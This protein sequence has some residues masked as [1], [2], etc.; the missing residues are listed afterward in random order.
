MKYQLL[1]HPNTIRSKFMKRFVMS[2]EEFCALYPDTRISET[3]YH[4]LYMWDRMI[5]RYEQITFEMALKM[6]RNK[7]DNVIFISESQDV[8]A[9]YHCEMQN[10]WEDINGAAATADM[11][12]L[13][14]RISYEWYTSYEMWEQG[15]QFED[16]LL[17]D[18]L[19]VFDDTYSWC[20]IFTHETVDYSEKAEARLCFCIN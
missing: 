15:C 12:E 4:S 2:Y 17:P 8:S 13:V 7:G 5:D 3:S 10:W 14:E 9:Y 6:L 11:A 1:S 19:Y 18:D 16:Y 20:I